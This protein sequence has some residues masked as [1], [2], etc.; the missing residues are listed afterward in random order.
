M[1]QTVSQAPGDSS[2]TRGPSLTSAIDI[3]VAVRGLLNSTSCLLV[4]PAGPPEPRPVQTANEALW[5]V[6]PTG[7]GGLVD[8]QAGEVTAHVGVAELQQPFDLVI[9]DDRPASAASDSRVIENLA[10]WAASTSSPR[11]V[12]VGDHVSATNRSMG[13]ARCARSL[14][15]HGYFRTFEP[16]LDV[17]PAAALYEHSRMSPPEIVARYEEA[18]AIDRCG[19]LKA[20]TCMAPIVERHDGLIAK[21]RLLGLMARVIRLQDDADYW[22]LKSEEMEVKSGTIRRDATRTATR[23]AVARVMAGRRYRLGAALLKPAE[24]MRRRGRRASRAG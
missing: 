3:A 12:V 17:V 9:L 19:P 5:H 20:D 15:A 23:Q 16:L 14:A 13:Q 11:I 4:H 7:A 1:D 21:D 22:R 2:V 18:L 8:D 6:C 24:F 10:T